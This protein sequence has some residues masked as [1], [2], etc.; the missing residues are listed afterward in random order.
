MALSDKLVA[1]AMKNLEKLLISKG[2]T[3]ESLIAKFDIN[4]DLS[5]IHISE[6][7]RPY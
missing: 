5:L 2:F 3:A 4:N 6:P 1:A 7:T